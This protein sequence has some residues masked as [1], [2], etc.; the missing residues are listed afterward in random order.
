MKRL[1]MKPYNHRLPNLAG[2]I[3][4]LVA[5]PALMGRSAERL[6]VLFLASDDMR[7]Q[8]GCYG[9]RIVQ[10]PHLDRLAAQGMVFNRAYCQQ[11]LCSPSR[12]SLLTG[13]HIW[14]TK[15]YDIGPFL[16]ET[17]PDVVTLPQH[18]KNH[19]YFT[20]SLGKIYHVGIDDL[21]S[22]SVPP[23]H[24]K[25]PRYGPA[26]SAAVTARR[27]ALQATGKPIPQKGENAP[28]YG[29]PAFEAPDLADDDLLD[30]DTVREALEAMRERAK[31]PEQPFFLAVGFANPHVPWVA[32]KKYWDLYRAAEL[33]LPENRYAPRNA[34]AFAATS[35]A[36][37]Y[38]YSNVPKDRNIT[39][40]FG[41]QCLQGYLAAISYVDAGIGRL[42]SE[43]DRLGLRDKTVVM[44]WG[45][46]GYYMGEHNWWGGK[47]NT[48]EGATRAPL[49]VSAPGMKADGSKTDA[50][51][52]FV[53]IYPSLVELC[54]LPKPKDAAGWEG[55]SFAPLLNDP[56]R[57]WDKVAFSE[58]PKGGNQG[59]AMRTDRYR[60]VEWR[61]K[62]GE[63]VARELYDH[64][65]DPQENEN[66]AGVAAHAPV[67]ER[68]AERLH[69]ARISGLST[70][71]TPAQ[72]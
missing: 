23:W 13:R 27:A 10:S 2:A 8:L 24:S 57:P 42:L 17:M 69:R 67:L 20:R 29:G 28:F 39:P 36:D 6:N 43:L 51:V 65:T 32:P 66:V 1:T 58:Y 59:I 26:G 60:Y 25:K 31:Q 49:L 14:T 11:A 55:K 54:G 18:F 63:L 70:V 44:F 34:P 4:L 19:G 38:W 15:I 62:Q 41:R 72:P 50:L 35:G 7:P 3:V 33:P 22:W 48:Y 37:F 40:E 21:Q 68:L 46:H 5:G 61:N 71:P 53:D 12:I 45:D 64:Q 9:D 16:R 30:G 47:H 52:E 56:K